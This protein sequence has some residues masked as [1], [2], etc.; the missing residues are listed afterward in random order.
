MNGTFT[1]TI[2]RI[3]DGRTAVV[4]IEDD[5]DIAE[6][7]DVPVEQLPE[8]AQKEGGVVTV[9]LTDGELDSIRYEPAETR[10]RR[11]AAQDRLDRL[12]KRLEDR[13]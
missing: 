13:E 2:D 3:V 9:E 11:E 12:S 6:Q 4:L 8:S 1:A 5:G 10:R 7:L